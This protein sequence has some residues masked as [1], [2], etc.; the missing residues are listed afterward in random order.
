MQEFTKRKQKG[1]LP[2]KRKGWVLAEK[3]KEKQMGPTTFV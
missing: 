1:K 2:G 3:L